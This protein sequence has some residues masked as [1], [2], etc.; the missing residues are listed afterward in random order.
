MS[1]YKFKKIVREACQKFAYRYLI[2]Q[3]NKLSKGKN[4]IYN[5]LK[6]HNYFKPGTVLGQD[7]MKQIYLLRTQNV[8]VKTN[9]P[10]M[11]PNDKCVS[12]LCMEKD[13]S[14]HVF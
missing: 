1:K 8:M 9:F 14:S 10:G 11:F 6:T 4:L 5:E 12:S 3:K 2:E 7:D 13:S